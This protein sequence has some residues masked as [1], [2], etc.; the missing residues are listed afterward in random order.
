MHII[1]VTFEGVEELAILEFQGSFATLQLVLGKIE[2]DNN[3][4]RFQSGPNFLVGRVI[5]LPKSLYVLTQNHDDQQNSLS[6]TGKV[7]LKIIFDQ[8]PDHYYS[9]I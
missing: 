3:I 9:E 7:T 5:K 4:A 1:N 6:I 8:E 2:I